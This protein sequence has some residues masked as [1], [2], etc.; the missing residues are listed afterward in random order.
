MRY[1]CNGRTLWGPSTVGLIRAG[2]MYVRGLPVRLMMRKA[3][4][5]VL[6]ARRARVRNARYLTTGGRLVLEDGAELQCLATA[7]IYLGASVSIG[8][9]AMVRPSSYYGGVIGE[10]LWVGDRSS[11]GP[12]CYIG[13]SGTIEIGDDVM[14]GPGVR[15]FS[16]NHVF[17]ET[18]IPIKAQG[19]QRGRT[20]IEDD[21]WIGSGVT[22][23]SGVRIGAH[24][25]VAAGAVVTRDVP[26]FSIVA[27]VPARVVK[28]R[29]GDIDGH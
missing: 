24:S 9:G 8:A 2:L 17:A 20:A 29:S 4:G 12:Q 5:P 28:R 16:E 22:I 25:V 11:I 23:T 1:F 15:I 7:G 10:G 6:I 21:C 3:G 18:S 19:V 26:P 13:C 14:L 27:G